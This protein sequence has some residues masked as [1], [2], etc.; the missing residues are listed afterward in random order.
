MKPLHSYTHMPSNADNPNLAMMLTMQQQ[1]VAI[2]QQITQLISQL[3]PATLPRTSVPRP[4]QS[5]QRSKPTRP[6]I[7]ADCTDNK[8]VI[9]KDAW[10]CYK[11]M[12]GLHDP[13][14]T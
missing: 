11:Q 14:E 2:Q 12:A 3:A 13:D 4:P 5:T 1:H 7:E 8:W 6:V 9:F 10:T